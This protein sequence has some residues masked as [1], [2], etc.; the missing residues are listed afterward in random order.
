MTRLHCACC[1]K[2]L[3]AS[4]VT[5]HAPTE[6]GRYV[7]R[8]GWTYE[9]NGRVV[10]RQYAHLLI[11]PEGEAVYSDTWNDGEPRYQGWRRE[12][13]LARVS[14]WDGES[15]LGWGNFCTIQCAAAYGQVAYRCG[16]RTPK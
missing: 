2:P 9:G 6:P 13:R 1:G 14:T 12:R 5:H 11:G 16:W 10:H 15:Y 8:Y 4:T 3:R 7:P